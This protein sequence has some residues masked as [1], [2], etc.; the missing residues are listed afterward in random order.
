MQLTLSSLSARIQA[1]AERLQSDYRL[2]AALVGPLESVV[3]E[4]APEAAPIS[5]LDPSI[6]DR[7]SGGGEPPILER[8]DSVETHMGQST[9]QFFLRNTWRARLYADT[10]DLL[11]VD[12]TLRSFEWRE[13]I[14]AARTC[15]FEK[16]NL[17][18]ASSSQ[19]MREQVALRHEIMVNTRWVDS[20]GRPDPVD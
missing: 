16:P 3:V 6:I 14:S 7:Y 5:Q 4:L 20:F 17:N 18:F 9:P 10:E 15:F 1:A 11:Y 12:R 19:L 2:G 13:E 8:P